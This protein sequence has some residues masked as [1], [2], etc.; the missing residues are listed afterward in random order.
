MLTGTAKSHILPTKIWNKYF[1][2]I[3]II[4]TA[5]G[6]CGQIFNATIALYIKNLG[7]STGTAGT[8]ISMSTI[9]SVIVSFFCGRLVDLKGRRIFILCGLII[10]AVTAILFK[11]LPFLAILP[12]LNFIMG[13]GST[14]SNIGMSAAVIDIVPKDRLGEGVGYYGLT[15]TLT[16]AV[17]APIG[18]AL[19]SGGAFDNLFNAA[20]VFVAF[21]IICSLF[22]NYEKKGFGYFKR[23]QNIAAS[24]KE[25]DAIDTAE[26][27]GF[28]RKFVEVGALP[29]F[30]TQ[31][32]FIIGCTFNLSFISL[33]AELEGIKNIGFFFTMSA[34]GMLAGRLFTSRLTDRVN[35]LFL[36][37]PGFI[38]GAVN[39]ILLIFAPENNILIY[40]SGVIYGLSLGIV[41]T[42]LNTLAIRNSAENRRGAASATY[43]LSITL[44]IGLGGILLGFVIDLTG[45][46][47]TLL[48]CTGLSVASIFFSILF[49]REKKA[50]NQI[51]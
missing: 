47:A 24:D 44:G 36:L 46:I 12:L 21:G 20:T 27:S 2:L 25:K 8:I 11:F 4:C 33:Y 1:I 23:G 49:F 39:F 15:Q 50:R 42:V 43:S 35:P 38:I 18:L 28:F 51:V 31:L 29:A 40:I 5:S 22:C 17:G 10:M 32:I 9:A 34:I 19:I 6:L 37:T 13:T 48:A 16:T 41:T 7:G 26:K 45:F 14:A 30:I 3:F